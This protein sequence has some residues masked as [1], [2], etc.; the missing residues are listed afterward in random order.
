MAEDQSHITEPA[1]VPSADDSLH[2]L[3]STNREIF[4]YFQAAYVSQSEQVQELK[5]E[6]IELDVKLEELEKTRDL[7][8]FQTDNNR[9]VFSPIPVNPEYK[10][11][12]QILSAQIEELQD[13]RTSLIDK[14]QAADRALAAIRSH[15]ESIEHAA[16]HLNLLSQ[17]IPKQEATASSE[18]VLS[19]PEEALIQD[20]DETYHA[21]QLLMLHQ[22]D[23]SQAAGQIQSSII[24]GLEKNSNKL[25]VLKWLIQ[26]DPTRARLTIQEL[27]DANN[28]L[29]QSS[30]QLIRRLNRSLSHQLPIW[31]AIDEMVQSYRSRHP[32]VT[33]H[34]SVDCTDYDI[35]VLPIITITVLQL[36]QEV[37]ENA[38]H[39]SNANKILIQ[40]YLNSR[41]I[42]LYINDNGAGIPSDHM[43]ASSWHS[44]LHRLNEIVHLF[45]GKLQID[46]DIISGTNVRF[47]LPIYLEP[48]EEQKS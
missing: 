41:M 24:D 38:F 35:Q 10:S 23:K 1:G 17:T 2:A 6:L 32:E 37:L 36:L 13:V 4:D 30:H 42:D 14:I 43:T 5:S 7:Y 48:K 46:G 22:Y 39:Y 25:E 45:D 12:G 19:P 8:S 47:S 44:G 40:V 31:K 15:M 20:S 9:S 21:C 11:R 33:I 16:D 26:S 34:L 18:E 3:L 27:Q 29:L 28:R